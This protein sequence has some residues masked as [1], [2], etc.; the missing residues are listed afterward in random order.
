MKNKEGVPH[1]DIEEM[2]EGERKKLILLKCK[3]MFLEYR[4]MAGVDGKLCAGKGSHVIVY[5]G[6]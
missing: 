6:I 4:K 1:E 3:N 5:K 2:I